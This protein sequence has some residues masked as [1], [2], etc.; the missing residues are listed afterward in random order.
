M[1]VGFLPVFLWRREARLRRNW[2]GQR[3]VPVRF[4]IFDYGSIGE[5]RKCSCKLGGRRKKMTVLHEAWKYKWELYKK[6]S[7]QTWLWRLWSWLSGIAYFY[8]YRNS[9]IFLRLDMSKMR[10]VIAV[11]R[12]CTRYIITGEHFMSCQMANEGPLRHTK[13]VSRSI[14]NIPRNNNASDSDEPDIAQEKDGRVAGSFSKS[15]RYCYGVF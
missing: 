5:W 7:W 9:V 13:M 4:Y 10:L 8:W 2:R 11:E 14:P 15:I 1:L 3:N 12:L 6:M